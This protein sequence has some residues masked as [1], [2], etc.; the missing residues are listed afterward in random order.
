MFLEPSAGSSGWYDYLT[1]S[2]GPL[3]NPTDTIESEHL[4]LDES[5]TDQLLEL[6]KGAMALTRETHVKQLEVPV[7][8]AARPNPRSSSSRS[9]RN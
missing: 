3:V 2:L 5:Y 9:D 8:P 1:W 4:A 6:F 7:F